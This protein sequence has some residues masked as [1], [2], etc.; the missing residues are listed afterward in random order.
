MSVHNGH[1][2][3]MRQE[4]LSGGLAHFSEPRVLELL[5]FYSRPRGD[6]NP[7]AHQLLETFGSL[8]GVLD[9]S[10][11]DLAQV[12]GMGENTVALLKLIPAIAARYL[13]SRTNTDV[14]ISDS[15]SLQALFVPY[16]FGA[17]NELSFVAC[18]DGKLK[19]LGV[20]QLSEG[21]PTANEINLR[22]ITT[23]AL[24]LNAT[25]VVLAHKHPSGVATP[26]QEDIFL[27][28]YVQQS[29]QPLGITLYDHVILTDD[30]MVSLRDSRHLTPPSAF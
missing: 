17:R 18:F 13:A 9:A 6:V 7:L 19:L 10:P 11:T 22:K 8:A 12:P 5:L 30:D 24:S 20:K 1:R 2:E 15:A 29:L 27:T 28:H 3:R 14:I 21:T 23:I 26:S 25:A 4:F 16:F